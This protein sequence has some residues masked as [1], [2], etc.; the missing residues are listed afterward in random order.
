MINDDFSAL[1][2]QGPRPG[3]V[4]QKKTKKTLEKLNGQAGHLVCTFFSPRARKEV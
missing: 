1:V 2:A 4:T 3:P